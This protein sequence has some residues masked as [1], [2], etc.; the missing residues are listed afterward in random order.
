MSPSVEP[1]EALEP[2]HASESGEPVEA[3][4][5]QGAATGFFPGFD[6][7]RAIAA[8]AVLL[9]HVWLASSYRG[10]LSPWLTQLDVGVPVF[11]VISGFLLYRPFVAGRLADREQQPTA[12]FWKRRALRIFPAYWVALILISVF[13]YEGP[14]PIESV[15]DFLT[16]A[17]LLQIYTDDRVING[18][19]QQSWTLAVE[20]AFYAF[21]PFYAMAIRRVRSRRWSPLTVEVAG[22]TALY[23]ISLGY[24]L[25]LL[26][27]DLTPSQ[28]SH[29]RLF[30]PGF[31]DTLALGM[32][33]AVLS[34]WWT[35]GGRRVAAP[36]WLAGAAWTVAAISYVLICKAIDLPLLPT[37]GRTDRQ[38]LV[39]QFLRGVF[40]V[41]LVVPAVFAA[42]RL[43]AIHR[44]LSA[45]VMVALGLISYGT[46]L[47]H[48]A[49]I[50]AYLQ[51]RDLLLFEPDMLNLWVFVIA[52]TIV[53]AAISY[54]VIEKPAMRLKSR[55]L[56]PAFLRRR[57]ATFGTFEKTLLFIM[58]VA[59][60]I[61]FT[62]AWFERRPQ[63]AEVGVIGDANFYYRGAQL[64]ADG[65]GFISTFSYDIFDRVIQDASHPPLYIL[66]LSIPSVLGFTTTTAHQLWTL[67]LGIATIGVVGYCGKEMIGPRV[68]LIAA[69][70]AAIYPNVW[71][72]DAILPS[73]TL[74]NSTTTHPVWMGN[75]YWRAPSMKRA[76]ALGL[77]V[78]L[79]V[80]ARSEMGMLIPFM[81]IP[82][83][84]ATRQTS[85][86]ERWKRL[87][88]TGAV[89]LV[90]VGPWVGWNLTRFEEPVTLATGYGITL[91]SA[92]CDTTHYGDSIGYWSM[93]CTIPT[94]DRIRA[95]EIDQSVAEA[96]YRKVAL[97]YIR[98]NKG[99]FAYVTLVRWARYIG[100]WDLL[101]DWDQVY[102][103]QNPEGRE[104]YVAWSAQMMWYAIAPL[105]VAGAVVLRRRRVPVYIVA[106]PI[107]ASIVTTTITFYQNRYRASAETAFCLLAA[108][109]IDAI[110]RAGQR[111]RGQATDGDG[112]N[113]STDDGGDGAPERER[114]GATA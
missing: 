34:A 93:D 90:V 47:W 70:L 52:T 39:E 62:Y 108:V 60:V 111:R 100:L 36:R 72:H 8:L 14:L 74:A 40:A 88:A 92:N 13:F 43:G 75:R 68:G 11:F 82:L 6:G 16:H 33:L 25:A 4:A 65:K 95:L 67:P 112:G 94:G 61:R 15:G 54:H 30:L 114:V 27:A 83:V 44:F 69:G 9:T 35:R 97:E 38:F 31:L 107:F 46:Y 41:A 106:A 79:A 37:E 51:W 23:L 81:V 28:F 24:R 64:L 86:K 26:S 78:A 17:L 22:I 77:A 7:L 18:P 63:F 3:A 98:E 105:A 21:L 42:P 1:Q 29:Y 71:S 109:S 10:S 85:W 5:H 101:H 80:F 45:R 50:D 66:W 49:M 104:P 55:T 56:T 87:V 89:V 110:V 48:E 19:V 103:D 53:V 59:F 96:E 76:L 12:G 91:L 99:R 102:K 113:D 58:F 20:V 32:G 57:I 84:L 73:E 2:A